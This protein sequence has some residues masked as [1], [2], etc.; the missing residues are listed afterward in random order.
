MGQYVG[1]QHAPKSTN[2]LNIILSLFYAMFVHRV[3]LVAQK[4]R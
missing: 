4:N 3:I 1:L 2:P